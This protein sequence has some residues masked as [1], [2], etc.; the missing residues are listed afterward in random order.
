M[1]VAAVTAVTVFLAVRVF[2]KKRETRKNAATVTK[3][4]I[5]PIKSIQGI[6]VDHLVIAPDGATYNDF[7]DR[8]MILL[9]KENRMI[10]Q[11]Q[12]GALA[13]VRSSIIGRSQMSLRAQCMEE[14]IIDLNK[15]SSASDS[16]LIHFR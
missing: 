8:G 5:Y 7:H 13:R 4:V 9:N 14:L 3:L 12:S 16:N 1:T 10:T 6:I 2:Y 11:R 15:I